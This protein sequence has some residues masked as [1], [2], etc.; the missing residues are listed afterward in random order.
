MNSMRSSVLSRSLTVLMAAS[1]IVGFTACG[2]GGATHVA[3]QSDTC[4]MSVPSTSSL[5]GPGATFNHLDFTSDPLDFALNN[6]GYLWLKSSDVAID[7]S[8][9]PVDPLLAADLGTDPYS[10]GYRLASTSKFT[11]DKPT[12]HAPTSGAQFRFVVPPV[13]VHFLSNLRQGSV[14]FLGYSPPETPSASWHLVLALAVAPDGTVTAG[15]RCEP[16]DLTKRVSQATGGVTSNGTGLE[17]AIQNPGSAIAQD[18]LGRQVSA[19]SWSE[20]PAS[21]RVIDPAQTPQSVLDTLV[22][23]SIVVT[24]P[25]SWQDGNHELCSRSEVGWNPCVLL[26]NPQPDPAPQHGLNSLELSY[27]QSKDS[28]FDISV[29]LLPAGAAF[30]NLPLAVVSVSAEQLRAS[31]QIAGVGPVDGTASLSVTPPTS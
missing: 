28:P 19:K 7:Q 18:L 12:P 30:D 21:E 31:D 26:D 20:T 13:A 4:T 1:A 27:Y 25:S 10:V 29:M 24:V 14:V 16:T 22:N 3:A 9:K 17:Q 15:D 23:E 8:S 6:A 5:F 11:V 2:S